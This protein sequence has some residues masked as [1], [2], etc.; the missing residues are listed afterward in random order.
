MQKEK[1]L[2]FEN[3]DRG[4]NEVLGVIKPLVKLLGLGKWVGGC[5]ALKVPSRGR[6]EA[7]EG[8]ALF[9]MRSL[10]SSRTG[11]FPTPVFFSVKKF[12]EVTI[13]S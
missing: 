8:F 12:H 7:D 10:V 1:W 3:I 5:A 4:S 11:K 13:P 9:A 2:V 6:V